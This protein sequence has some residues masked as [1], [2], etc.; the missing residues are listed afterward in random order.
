MSGGHWSSAA[1]KIQNILEEVG[2]DDYIKKDFSKLSKCLTD[3]GDALYDIINTLDYDISGDSFIKNKEEY[4]KY[5]IKLL[6][7]SLR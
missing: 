2:V 6:K 4:Q 3:L 7:K 5:A 1:F